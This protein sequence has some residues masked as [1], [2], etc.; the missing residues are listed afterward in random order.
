MFY[1]LKAHACYF[2]LLYISQLEE[3][4]NLIF[5]HILHSQTYPSVAKARTHKYLYSLYRSPTAF[6]S[7]WSVM[8][9]L[10]HTTTTQNFF[11]YY[12]LIKCYS[13][14]SPESVKIPSNSIRFNFQKVCS[15]SRKPKTTLEIRKNATFLY[16]I[17][18]LLFTSFSKTLLT[19]E[20]R[21]TG[22]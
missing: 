20:R 5:S 3:L 9:T 6:S 19:T 14:S 1:S 18:S 13:S 2:T 4:L 7:A 11:L 15:W 21:L 12:P 22:W 8:I 16:V 17:N 10:L